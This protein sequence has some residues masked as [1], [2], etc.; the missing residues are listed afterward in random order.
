MARSSDLSSDIESTRRSRPLVYAVNRLV[1]V[2][3]NAAVLG[4]LVSAFVEAF[5]IGPDVGLRSFAAAALP[6]IIL[7][8]SSFFSRSVRASGRVLEVNLFAIAL[9]W[10]LMLLILVNFVTIQ[11]NHS[12]PLGEFLISLT[13]STLFA[14]NRRLSTR[15]MLSCAYG[16]LSGFLLHL[17]IFGLPSR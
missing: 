2:A 4:L 11:F 1:I 3:A 9:L 17:L 13:L 16:I 6:P 14:L 7:T 10:I 12:I 8:Y 5:S 15:S